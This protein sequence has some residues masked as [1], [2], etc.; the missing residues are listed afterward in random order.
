MLL[1]CIYESSKLHFIIAP[2]WHFCLSI[3]TEI[4]SVSFS[5]LRR[6]LYTTEEMIFTGSYLPKESL[7]LEF[8]GKKNGEGRCNSD[9]EELGLQDL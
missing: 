4:Y 7:C 3:K 6:G 8:Q 9:S 2:I 1:R 5:P